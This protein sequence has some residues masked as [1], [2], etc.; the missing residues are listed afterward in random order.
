MT[1][2]RTVEEARRCY[3]EIAANFSFHN[4]RSPYLE[5]FLFPPQFNTADPDVQYFPYSVK[6]YPLS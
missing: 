5:S 3:T 2:Q 4:I 6:D 1:C